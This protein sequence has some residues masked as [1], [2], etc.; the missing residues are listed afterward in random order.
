M[1]NLLFLLA[2][3]IDTGISAQ[4]SNPHYDSTL[5]KS[6]GADDYGMKSYILVI[7]KTGPSTLTDQDKLNGI[8]SGHMD[9]IQRL[10]NMGKLIVA[11]PFSRNEESFRGIFILDVKT[12]EEAHALLETDP[13]VREKIFETELFEW[14]GSAALGEYLKVHEKIEKYSY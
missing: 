11:G 9:N 6:L 2:F 13:A 7:L 14:Y 10:A 12:R 4:T 3:M 8:F 1:K 5:A